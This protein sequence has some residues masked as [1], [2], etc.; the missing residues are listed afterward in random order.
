MLRSVPEVTYGECAEDDRAE[1]VVFPGCDGCDGCYSC[2]CCEHCG[3]KVV[4]H[5]VQT[6]SFSILGIKNAPFSGAAGI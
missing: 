3:R 2:D 4:F 5:E 1:E 6:P